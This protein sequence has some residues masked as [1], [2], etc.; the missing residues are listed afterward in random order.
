MDLETPMLVI[1]G[2]VTHEIQEGKLCR[3]ALCPWFSTSSVVNF[4]WGSPYDFGECE[5][6]GVLRHAPLV[7]LGAPPWGCEIAASTNIV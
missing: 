5:L 4:R 7:G 2:R 6:V 3:M 1:G